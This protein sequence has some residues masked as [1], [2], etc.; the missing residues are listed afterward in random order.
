MDTVREL[1]ETN[2]LLVMAMLRQFRGGGGRT[3]WST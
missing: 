3:S 2:A 1:F